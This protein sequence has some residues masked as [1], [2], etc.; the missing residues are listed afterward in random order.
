MLVIA[1]N[2]CGGWLYQR[3]NVPYNNPFIWM[4]APYKSILTVMEH[5]RDIHWGNFQLRESRTRLGT[6]IISVD[7]QIDLH[8]VHYKFNPLVSHAI[9]DRQLNK[10]GG[11]RDVESNHIWEYVVDKYIERTKRMLR[12][13]EPP[14]FLLRDETYAS[15]INQL[16]VCMYHSS[17]Y[18]RIIITANKGLNRNDSVVTT[19]HPNATLINDP[20]RCVNTFFDRIIQFIGG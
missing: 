10:S 19:I 12:S 9:V 1:N 15:D 18:K 5:F 6:F 2:C 3:A 13:N 16:P 8:Y 17:P 11:V 14:V 20:R 4:V 7:G